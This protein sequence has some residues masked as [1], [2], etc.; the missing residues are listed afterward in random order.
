MEIKIIFIFI[1]I[2]FIDSSN[3][4]KNPIRGGIPLVLSSIKKIN[5]FGCVFFIC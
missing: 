2:I 1:S 4:G 5:K 3:F